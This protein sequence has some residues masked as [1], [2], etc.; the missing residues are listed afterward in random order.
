[1]IVR[2]SAELDAHFAVVFI[3]SETSQSFVQSEQVGVA[4]SHFNVGSMK[5]APIELPSLA[6]QKEIARRVNELFDLTALL[7]AR[8]DAGRAMVD[9]LT[10]STLAKAFRGEL[11]PQD[12]SDE[13]ASELLA[14][15][16]ARTETPVRKTKQAEASDGRGAR[17]TRQR[18][19]T[20]ANTGGA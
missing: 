14:R 7:D 9:G 17:A 18:R 16:R 15:I 8:T 1:V 4:Q 3:N 2:P 10:R 11:V 13:P 5:R 12:P 20:M 6:E 19:P